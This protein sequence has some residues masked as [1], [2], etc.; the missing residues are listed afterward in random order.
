LV[1]LG[2]DILLG[3]DFNEAPLTGLA[4]Y[5]GRP[6]LVAIPTDIARLRARD[7]SLGARWRQAVRDAMLATLEEGYRI[8]AMARDGWYLLEAEGWS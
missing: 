8:T 2:A 4:T 3:R 6:V 5:D 1:R 7:P